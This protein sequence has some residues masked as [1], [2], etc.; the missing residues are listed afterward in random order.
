MKTLAVAVI[1]G[2]AFIL[3][4]LW[5]IVSESF[6]FGRDCADGFLDREADKRSQLDDPNNIGG[7][8]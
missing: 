1:F 6:N 4:F 7:W 5:H 8:E 2:P 3:G